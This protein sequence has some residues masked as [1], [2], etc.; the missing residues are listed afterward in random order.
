MVDTDADTAVH[1]VDLVAG[2]AAPQCSPANLVVTA[3]LRDLV[4][5]ALD[6][7]SP[8]RRDRGGGDELLALM[9]TDER[10]SEQARLLRAEPTAWNVQPA[11]S[12]GGA[13]GSIP[14]GRACLRAR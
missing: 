5:Q 11:R 14:S 7:A 3:V 4:E 8:A 1:L 2:E 12:D 13:G 9:A 6:G 10:T